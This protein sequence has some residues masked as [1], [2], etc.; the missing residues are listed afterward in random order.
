VQL[1]T[2]FRPHWRRVLHSGIVSSQLG[3]QIRPIGD[4]LLW[5]AY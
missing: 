1:E 4:L 3:D 5:V 2:K